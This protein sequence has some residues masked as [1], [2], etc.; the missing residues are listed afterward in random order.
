MSDWGYLRWL[1]ELAQR[2]GNHS[3]TIECRVLVSQRN[4]GRRVPDT[5]HEF[6]GGCT[7][8]SSK[9]ATSV[10]QVVQTKIGS[11]DCCAL[12]PTTLGGAS[13]ESCTPPYRRTRGRLVWH[14]CTGQGDWRFGLRDV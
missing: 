6:S 5:M 10:P 14:L 9:S 11:T 12:S 4:S 2:I 13:L 3:I 8:R 7:S 1:N